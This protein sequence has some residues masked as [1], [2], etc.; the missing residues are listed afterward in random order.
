MPLRA[1]EVREQRVEFVV[2]GL[3]GERLSC[4]CREFGVSRPAGYKWVERCQ[5]G[6]VEAIASSPVPHSAPTESR[7]HPT[8]PKA[9]DRPACGDLSD[10][11]GRFGGH[12]HTA[13]H[14]KLWSGC[15]TWKRFK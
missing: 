5:Q 2:R 10:S 11:S 8:N 1:M 9:A 3:R 6:G 13:I 12:A 15:W 14:H 4:L 7:V